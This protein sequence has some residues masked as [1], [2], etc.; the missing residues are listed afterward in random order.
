MFSGAIEV[1]QWLK[2]GHYE[3]GNYSSQRKI[4]KS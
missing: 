2:M 4:R 3:N 1:K